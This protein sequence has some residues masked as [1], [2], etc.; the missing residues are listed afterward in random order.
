MSRALDVVTL[1][2]EEYDDLME[3]KE[4]VTSLLAQLSAA[5]DRIAELTPVAGMDWRET[6][7]RM[8]TRM[9]ETDRWPAICDEARA[10]LSLANDATREPAAYLWG[11]CLWRTDE[12]GRGRPGAVELYRAQTP[13]TDA[14]ITALLP[15]WQQGSW[16]LPDYGRW[17]ARAVERAH[18]IKTSHNLCLS[19]GHSIDAHDRQYGCAE[20]GCDCETPNWFS[21]D[22]MREY[23]RDVE[24]AAYERAAQECEP[25]EDDDSIDRQIKRE[26]A[27]RIR[28]LGR[29]R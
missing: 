25:H 21:T 29:Q 19:C 9:E 11:G 3:C 23:A 24:R 27:E 10:V 12:M 7:Q 5:K 18:G 13:L 1:T 20:D 28:A 16:T 26:L 4:M 14:D 15:I 2:G 8:L 6:M 17:V 22:Q